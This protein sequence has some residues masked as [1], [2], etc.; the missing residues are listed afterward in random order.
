MNNSSTFHAND[1][2]RVS[3]AY[4]G[5]LR[6]VRRTESAI[7][8]NKNPANNTAGISHATVKRGSAHAQ[9]SPQKTN[10]PSVE[11]QR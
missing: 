8:N 5:V 1:K 11:A 9:I 3:P 4:S 6:T 10:T 7:P 2:N